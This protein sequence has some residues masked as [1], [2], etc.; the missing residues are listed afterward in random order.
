MTV[1]N[2]GMKINNNDSISLSHFKSV[3][4]NEIDKKY[5]DKNE[6]DKLYVNEDS[7]DLVNK[8]YV[9]SLEDRVRTAINKM[10]EEITGKLFL[11]EI[12]SKVTGT[13]LE[14]MLMYYNIAL[15]HKPKVWLSSQFLNR[16]FPKLN[17]GSE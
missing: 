17:Y 15:T 11:K 4:L 2:L 12:T 3:L 6:G 8:Q 13:M 14:K 9:G 5:L 7:H 1:N 10:K 16:L